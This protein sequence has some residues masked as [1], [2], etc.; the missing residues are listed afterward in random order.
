MSELKV[1]KIS[2]ATGTET[3]LGDSSDDFLLPSGAEIIAQS[4][5]TIT[6]ASGATIANAGTATGFAAAGGTTAHGVLA[7]SSGN[8]AFGSIPTGTKRIDIIFSALSDDN[9][10]D[11]KIRIGD[12]GGIETSGYVIN[13]TKV[14]STATHAL[15]VDSFMMHSAHST[16]YIT[17][18]VMSLYLVDPATYTWVSVHVLGQTTT[19]RSVLGG[20]SKSLSAE[21]TQ[22][23]ILPA[24]GN[25]DAGKVNVH[26][27]Q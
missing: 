9:A 26:Y 16:S 6:I 10:Q 22:L 24:S 3:T 4:G 12:A 1:N 8:M 14:E 2:P 25:I 7:G 21:L 5:S 20:G 15:C 18:G 19:L 23:A 11:Y 27:W 17:H 13:T